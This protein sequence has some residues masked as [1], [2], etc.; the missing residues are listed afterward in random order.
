MAGYLQASAVYLDACVAHFHV[1]GAPVE[2]DF[3]MHLALHQVQLAGAAA[4][5]DVHRAG[6]VQVQCRA[7]RQAYAAALSHIG[8]QL[9]GQ[10]LHQRPVQVGCS[11]QP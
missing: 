3:Q 10:T 4:Q 8:V 1:H 6:A 2:H 5:V 7:I 11:T 9:A